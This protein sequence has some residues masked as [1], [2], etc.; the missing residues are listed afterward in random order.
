MEELERFARR[1]PPA[2]EATELEWS[3]FLV[4]RIRQVRERERRPVIRAHIGIAAET[5]EPTVQAIEQLA[6][7]GAFE[8]VSLAPDQTSQELLAKFIRGEEDPGKYLAGQG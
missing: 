8:I 1:L 4:E 3:D 7:A 5:I 2:H 6:D